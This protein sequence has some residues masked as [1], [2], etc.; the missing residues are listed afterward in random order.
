MG[1]AEGRPPVLLFCHEKQNC[2]KIEVIDHLATFPQDIITPTVEGCAVLAKR[3]KAMTTA[4][5]SIVAGVVG[6]NSVQEFVAATSNMRPD[7]LAMLRD[8]IGR[9]GLQQT[10]AP[11]AL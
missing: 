7:S 3:V 6:A 8:E 2:L 5:L 4:A 11:T 10:H 1:V 9:M